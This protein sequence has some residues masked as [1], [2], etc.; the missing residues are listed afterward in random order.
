MVS[1]RLGT[2]DGGL[3]AVAMGCPNAWAFEAAKTSS[4]QAVLGDLRGRKVTKEHKRCLNC[5]RSGDFAIWG[6]NNT[7]AW[8]QTKHS[9]QGES[10]TS[11]TMERIQLNQVTELVG[12]PLAM[13]EN[14]RQWWMGR[15]LSKIQQWESMVRYRYRSQA[16]DFHNSYQTIKHLLELAIASRWQNPSDKIDG[17][18]SHLI[19]TFCFHHVSWKKP[20]SSN[21]K[22]CTCQW[23]YCESQSKGGSSGQATFAWWQHQAFLSGDQPRSQLQLPEK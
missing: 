16:I 14:P 7:S 22:R 23:S 15:L 19:L 1:R 21:R 13:L 12:C 8:G 4:R 6:C 10:L 9:G 2:P 3:G 5:W 11:S 17:K 18:L 20:K